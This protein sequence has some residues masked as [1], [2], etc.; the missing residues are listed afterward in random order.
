MANLH[1]T[2]LVDHRAELAD[3]VSIG[4]Y[5][6][7]KGPVQIGPGTIIHEHVHV[8]GKTLIGE[9]CEIGPAAYVGLPPQ[10][11]RGDREIGQL[12][13]GNHV[14]IRETATVHRAI[15]GGIENATRVGDHCFLM[16]GVHIAHDCALGDHVV[17]AN[18]VLLGG[19][20][21]IAE[22]SFLGGGCT[23]HQFV[24]VGRL[25]IIGGNERVVQEVLPFAAV[26]DGGLR[27]YNAVG[28]RRAGMSRASIHAIRAAYRC[29]H[30][31]RLTDRAIDDIQ[32]NVPD[33][34]EVREILEFI[35]TARRGI[36]PSVGG[37][38]M[39]FEE[40][41]ESAEASAD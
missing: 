41:R 16:G 23:L 1:P 36:V 3:D 27:G 9:K 33:V 5:A 14:T 37:R 10:H 7:I 8:Q 20:C 32:T 13:I 25:S 40:I 29:I 22:R 17:L 34:P 28:C 30:L 4:A 11:L 6:I 19:H 35:R 2:A 26:A 31:H 24:R 38:R 15:H 39:V 18:G 12:V 21:Q